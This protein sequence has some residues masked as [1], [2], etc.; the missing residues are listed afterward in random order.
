M[1]VKVRV[2]VARAKVHNSLAISS[3]VRYLLRN[4]T[5]CFTDLCK[6]QSWAIVQKRCR[7]LAYLTRVIG[8]NQ[9]TLV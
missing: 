7:L 9:P 3:G 2:S 5:G 6:I 1:Y 4:V 8:P